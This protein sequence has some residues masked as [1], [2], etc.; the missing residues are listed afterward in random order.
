MGRVTAADERPFSELTFAPIDD[1]A[2][3]EGKRQLVRKGEWYAAAIW[4]G[5]MWAYPP[6]LEGG[7]IVQLPFEPTVYE[8][9]S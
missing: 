3:V 4:T 7:S 8:V 5:D 2:K 1:A 6:E 9:K